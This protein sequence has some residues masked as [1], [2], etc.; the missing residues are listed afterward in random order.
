MKDLIVAGLNRYIESD[1]ERAAGLDQIKG[2][3]IRLTIHEIDKTLCLRVQQR[4]LQEETDRGIDADVE[5]SISLKILPEY[6]L[7]ADQDKLIKNGGIEIK[8]D[9]HIASVLQ[10]TLREIEIDWEELLSKYTGDAVA[11]QVGKGAQA[12]HSFGCRLRENMRQDVRDYLQ[13]NVQASATQDEVD[14]F[15][16]DVDQVRAKADRLEAR[17]NRLQNRN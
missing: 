9:T 11:Y 6:L 8:G 1:Q 14:Q 17:L 16:Q 10:N 12:M 4:Y 2:K 7:G 13:D 5:I 15:I 3:L